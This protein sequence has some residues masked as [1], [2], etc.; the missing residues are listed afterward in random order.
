MR[1]PD[2][3][4]PASLRGPAGVHI[5][6]AAAKPL[7][8]RYR[9][10]D[11]AGRPFD[12]PSGARRRV[13][14]DGRGQARGPSGVALSPA[15]RRARRRHAPPARRR[16]RAAAAR[17][18]RAR[19]SSAS[20]SPRAIAS[21][22]WPGPTAPTWPRRRWQRMRFA[23]GVDDDLRPFYDRFR[24]DPLIGRLGAR[25][26]VPARHP[27]PRAVRGAGV[28]DLRA[29][30]RVRARRGHPAADRLPARAPLRDAP[31]CATCRRPR[32]WPAPRPRCCSRW[33]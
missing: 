20:A 19:R 32:R 27:P 14:P 10:S 18:G 15:P 13:A 6:N 2:V 25:A 5:G 29:A 1:T 26:P 24:S 3:T 17:R 31:A 12:R 7:S 21:C 11:V 4:G 23:L 33:T 30:H 8:L 9:P 22:S 28:G 16:P